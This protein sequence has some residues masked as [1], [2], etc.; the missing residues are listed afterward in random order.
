MSRLKLFFI[1]VDIAARPISGVNMPVDFAS[2]LLSASPPGF[3]SLH[4]YTSLKPSSSEPVLRSSSDSLYAQIFAAVTTTTTT[5]V[6]VPKTKTYTL[7]REG[8]SNNRK[9]RVS[10]ADEL[11]KALTQ[12]RIMSE[13]SNSPPL[14]VSNSSFL[15]ISG[16]S[17]IES[18]N[19]VNGRNASLPIGCT[20]RQGDLI[21]DF[22]QP[23][24]LYERFQNRLSE[25]K[26][27]VENVVA[28]TTHVAGTIMVANVGFEKQVYVRYTRNAWISND[29]VK[30]VYTAPESSSTKNNSRYDRFSFELHLGDDIDRAEFCV[31]YVVSGQ[32]YWDSNGGFN[33]TIVTPRCKGLVSPP[34]T[35]ALLNETP[36]CTQPLP[37]SRRNSADAET[38]F[39]LDFHDNWSDFGW[40]QHSQGVQNPYY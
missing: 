6:P 29:E 36:S 20:D 26:V 31:R 35:P 40:W 22:V 1:M 39:A 8:S 37:I 2:Y 14:L 23:V 12:V 33:Y 16:Q 10:F 15:S 13:P 21:L 30:A 17:N 27:S 34:R 3:D 7:K 24:S 18:S 25:Q 9:K 28:R 5:T 38:I 4:Q 19:E 11:G 32:E